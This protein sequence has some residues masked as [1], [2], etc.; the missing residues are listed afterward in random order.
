VS[1]ARRIVAALALLGA[2]SAPVG[3]AHAIHD[4]P[5]FTNEEGVPVVHL[6]AAA[7]DSIG[8]AISADN[9][10]RIDR[11]DAA[12]GNGRYGEPGSDEARENALAAFIYTARVAFDFVLAIAEQREVIYST[13]ETDLR[14]AFTKSFRNPGIYPIMN[15]VDARAGFGHFCL[16][17]DVDDPDRREIMVSGE[18]MRSWTEVVDIDDVPRRVVNID[19]KTFSHDRVHVVYEQ[20]SC[21]TVREFESEMNG[22]PIHIATMEE[23]DGQYVR[24]FGF[25]KPAAL[26]LWKSKVTADIAPP[27]SGHRYLGSAIYIPHLKLDLPWFLPSIGFDDLK[28]FDFPEPVLSTKAVEELRERDIDWMEIRENMRFADWEGEGDVPPFVNDRFPDY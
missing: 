13:S 5:L 18:K 2:A 10:A 15:L 8:R 27:P 9:M 4:C 1:G 19:M 24:K 12:Y 28:R 22:W 14:E 21:G 16:Q 26:V 25:H 11:I 20:F 3:P 6:D 17:F 23:L 7:I